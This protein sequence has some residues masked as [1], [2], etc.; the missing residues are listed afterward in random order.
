M[1]RISRRSMLSAVLKIPAAVSISQTFLLA[2]QSNLDKLANLQFVGNVRFKYNDEFVYAWH[3]DEGQIGAPTPWHFSIS[4]KSKI[5]AGTFVQEADSAFGVSP[6]SSNGYRGNWVRFPPSLVIEW[7]WQAIPGQHFQFWN[8][9]RQ[10]H[11]NPQDD[12]MFYFDIVDHANSTVKIRSKWS[13]YLHL[14][15]DRFN[16]GAEE[17]QAAVF[18]VVFLP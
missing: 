8:E 17:A 4:P 16:T 14:D 18:T 9:D 7:A 15:G 6:G 11:G 13:K 12:E 2:Q 10:A 3:L 5:P 1:K